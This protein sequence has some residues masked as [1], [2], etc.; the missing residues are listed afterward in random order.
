MTTMLLG[1]ALFF[2]PH[3]LHLF[4][5]GWRTRTIAR[6]GE[7]PWKGGY[8]ALS[9]LGLALV[10]HGYGEARLAP[11]VVWVPPAWTGHL[12][13]LL[14]APAFVLL[15]AAYVPG[16]RIRARVG[17]PMVAG[18]VLWAL[19]HLL[20]NGTVADLVLF[21]SF[22]AWSAASLVVKRRRDL[23]AGTHRPPGT[24]SR[25]VVT[26]VVGLGLWAAFALWL[27]A[28]LIGVRPFG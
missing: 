16:N 23:R 4:A 3:A 11:D 12:A 7:L 2:A 13:A 27:H 17:H 20:A 14:L 1:L 5:P 19:A 24:I 28:W 21:G 25:D 9:L 22:L 8:A 15:T 6:V 10:V 26:V 18:V